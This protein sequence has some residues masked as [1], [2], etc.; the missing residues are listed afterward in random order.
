MSIR[1]WLADA[2]ELEGQLLVWRSGL[3]EAFSYTKRN[4]YEQLVVNKQTLYVFVHA[5]YHQCLLV[6]HSSLVPL[7][8]GLDLPET[9]PPG[10][11]SVSARTALRSAQEVSGIGADLLALDW[12]PTQIPAFVGYCMFVHQSILRSLVPGTQH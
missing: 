8:S 12:D 7:F 6:L 2:F 9:V 11:T 4:L 1:Q 10:V 3:S 5:L